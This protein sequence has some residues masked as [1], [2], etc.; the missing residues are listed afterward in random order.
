MAAP[1]APGDQILNLIHASPVGTTVGNWELTAKTVAP[2]V[3]FRV[4]TA[5]VTGPGNRVFT[6]AYTE[7]SDGSLGMIRHIVDSDGARYRWNGA[8]WF[9][10]DGG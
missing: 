8:S 5:V 9:R 1:V 7:Q 3:G 2:G 4:W 10:S 6:A